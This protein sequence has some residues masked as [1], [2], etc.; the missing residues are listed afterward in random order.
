M[1]PVFLALPKHPFDYVYLHSLLK[2]YRSPRVKIG[3][4]LKKREIIRIK[5]G[6]YI[7]S[8]EYGG[9]ID[10]LVLSNLIYGPSYVSLEYALSYWG[11]IPERVEVITGVTNKRN[12]TFETPIGN[13]SYRYVNN[14]VFPLGRVLI[15]EKE[16][17][18]IIASKEKS[19][20]DQIGSIKQIRTIQD[21]ISYLETDLRIDL[22]EIEDLDTNL[23]MT[24]SD[25]YR[26]PS[27]SLFVK[28]ALKKYSQK[29]E[30]Y[31]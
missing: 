13:F 15:R 3:S 18:F 8:P 12:K 9:E 23:L 28:W 19:L 2:E 21:V 11:L 14:Q 20:C 17:S 7:L 1:K 5:K 22:E 6:L 4:M 25:C 30:A 24:L 29:K 27:V 10:K 16:S 26:K 31:G